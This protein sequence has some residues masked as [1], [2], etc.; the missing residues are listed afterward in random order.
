MLTQALCLTYNTSTIATLASARSFLFTPGSDERKLARAL[1]CG[2]DAVIADLED[3]VIAAEKASARELARN[4]LAGAPDGVVTLVRL[5]AAGT[6]WFEEDLAMATELS[7]DAVVLPK[8]SVESV[9]SL[10]PSGLTAIAI[11][12]TAAAVRTAYEIASA[13][14]VVALLVGALDLGVELRLEPRPD[15]LELHY[16]RSKLGVDRPAR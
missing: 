7:P 13:D 5:N 10:A 8:A 15:G 3:S 16:T 11:V 2:A 6:P 12:E 1:D 9:E 14:A 4:Y